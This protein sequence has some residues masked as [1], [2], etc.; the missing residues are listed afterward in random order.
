M[1]SPGFGPFLTPAAGSSQSGNGFLRDKIGVGRGDRIAS[2]TMLVSFECRDV[3]RILP[4]SIGLGGTGLG[5]RKWV[6]TC[7]HRRC[8]TAWPPA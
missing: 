8:R 2:Q 1:L 7:F 3:A 6:V 4:S 5:L